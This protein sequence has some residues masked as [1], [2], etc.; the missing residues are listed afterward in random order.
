MITEKEFMN[1]LGQIHPLGDMERKHIF[2]TFLKLGLI[3]H[4]P[5]AKEK[6]ERTKKY[7]GIVF[8]SALNIPGEWFSI[9]VVNDIFNFADAAIKEAEERKKENVF[10]SEITEMVR[11]ANSKIKEERNNK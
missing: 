4:E 7:S 6:Y 2:D 5:T 11:L 9:E 3:E 8:D 10:S 1:A